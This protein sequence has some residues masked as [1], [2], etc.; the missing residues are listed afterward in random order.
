MSSKDAIQCSL[1]IRT[2]SLKVY[3]TSDLLL[4]PH[5]F[6]FQGVN[7]VFNIHVIISVNNDELWLPCKSGDELTKGSKAQRI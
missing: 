1:S 2:G 6:T 7:Q 3:V 5:T 4:Q